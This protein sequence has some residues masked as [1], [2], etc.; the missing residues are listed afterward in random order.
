ML[1]LLKRL[2]GDAPMKEQVMALLTGGAAKQC[3]ATFGDKEFSIVNAVSSQA[4]GT[5][6]SALRALADK[7]FV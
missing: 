6:A 7:S 1:Y 3:I 5:K 2:Q 4:Q